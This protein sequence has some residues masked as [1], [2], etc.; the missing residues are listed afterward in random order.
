LSIAFEPGTTV[1]E[2]DLL[3]QQDT[4]TEQA[5]LRAAQASVALA[6]V[7]LKRDHDLIAQSTISQSELDVAEAQFKQ[8]EAQADDIRAAISKK[9]I[10]A[11]FA[12]RLGIRL[13]NLGQSL[14]S[15]DP[16]VSLQVL[17]PIFVDFQLPQ[18]RL[19]E[20]A[21]D[22]VVRVTS[23]ALA[24]NEVVEGRITAINPDVDSATRN[25]RVQATLANARERLHPGM[26]V[27][28]SVLLP[29][30]EQVLAIPSTAVLYAPYGNSVFVVEEKK[31]EN[32]GTRD[33]VVRQQVV[34]LGENRGDF[35][36]VTAGLKAGEIVVTTG[37]FKLRNGIAVTVDNQLAPAAELAPKPNDT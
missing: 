31:G 5:Q 1:K 30:A 12:G 37:V 36:A 35:V 17:D 29:R 10:R 23:D 18:Q 24:P 33:R 22:L 7:S 2:G 4:S 21:R 20:I 25:V 27:H 28:A 19:A 15:G 13:V 11:P 9:T 3:V 32:G 16:I 14:K 34:R 6:Q 26:F 8:A